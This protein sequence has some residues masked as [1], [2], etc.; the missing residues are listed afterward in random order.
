MILGLLG[1]T[2]C[3]SLSLARPEKRPEE[4]LPS[5]RFSS[6]AFDSNVHGDPIRLSFIQ[7]ATIADLVA[8][9]FLIIRKPDHLARKLKGI[10]A[11]TSSG[12]ADLSPSLLVSE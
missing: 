5:G 12:N 10:K 11:I 7:S 1:P 6:H 9:L 3:F 4:D 2:S 8:R